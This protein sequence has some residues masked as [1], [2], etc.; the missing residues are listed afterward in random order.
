MFGPYNLFTFME[1]LPETWKTYFYL[2]VGHP[3]K[4]ADFL[5]ERSPSTHMHNLACPM[6]V[7]QGA[8]DPRVT[9]RESRD[10]V[11]QLRAQGKGVEYVVYADEG[12]DVIT[13][14]NKVDCY[15]RIADFFSANL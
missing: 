7:I 2:A 9:E 4:E 10:V 11:E 6:L 15:S 14:A 3:E 13:Y 8:H 1:R 12:H 5:R